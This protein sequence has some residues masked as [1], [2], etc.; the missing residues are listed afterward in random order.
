VKIF[1]S[2]RIRKIVGKRR[3]AGLIVKTRDIA[4]KNIQDRQSR[5]KQIGVCKECAS[6]NSPRVG[7]IGTS[8]I[9]EAKGLWHLINMEISAASAYTRLSENISFV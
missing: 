3:D 7:F 1:L 4:H 6:G 8:A 9:M 5:G 2:S